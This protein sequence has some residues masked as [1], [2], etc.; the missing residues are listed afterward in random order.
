[1]KIIPDFSL[2]IFVGGV[3]NE[4][5][6]WYEVIFDD[7]KVKSVNLSMLST[8]DKVNILPNILMEFLVRYKISLF[9]DRIAKV[10][11]IFAK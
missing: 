1:M 7:L 5:I 6:P 9:I 3:R 4:A 8:S 11:K 2:E 10:A